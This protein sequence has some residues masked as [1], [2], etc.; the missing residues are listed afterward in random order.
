MNPPH[1]RTAEDAAARRIAQLEERH[2]QLEERLARLEARAGYSE[3]EH[4]AA[5]QAPADALADIERT[6]AAIELQVGQNGFAVAGILAL[7]IG[8]GFMLCLPFASLPPVAPAIAGC[9][10]AACF[11]LLAHLL[12]RAFRL[13]AGNLRGAGMALLFLSTLRLYFFG[14]VHALR[15]G[16]LAGRGPLVLVVALNLAIAWRRKSPWLTGLALLTGY[17]AAIA[18]GSAWFVLG[19]VAVLSALAVAASLRAD[20]P[21]LRVAAIPLSYGTYCIWAIGDPVLGGALKFTTAPALAPGFLLAVACIFAA[22]S[23]LRPNRPQ[24]DA[25]TAVGA[26]LNCGLGY[27]LFLWHTAVAFDP[28]LAGAHALAAAVFLGLA[29]LFWA[30]ENSR[31]STFFYAMTGYAALSVAILKASGAPQVFVWLSLQSVVVVTTAV[32]FRSRFIV[33]SNFLIFVAIV[34]GYV[35]VAERE[36]GISILFGIAAM[37]SAR[38]LNWKKDRLELKT[39]LMRNAYLACAFLVFPYSL[40]HLVP[41]KSVGLAWVGLALG[42][43]AMGLYVKNRKYR[44]MG[45]ATLLLA[46]CHVAAVGTR[47]FEP[48]YR[49]ASFLALGTVLVVVSLSFTRWQ[50]RQRAKPAEPP[51]G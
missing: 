3:G 13:V 12:Q 39:E 10:I 20:W 33:V 22:G 8:A 42:Y 15:T 9:T 32:W 41:R 18:V 35:A 29:V 43:Y 47:G 26:L 30:R 19:S 44:W 23:L 46:A 4:P 17:A 2:A 5:A 36:T 45:H 49:I 28:G 24:E 11:F 51:A 1:E 21:I 25:R 48:A 38:I 34:L 27:F 40:Y 31:A 14:A 50:S 6:E 7:A 16:G 37:L